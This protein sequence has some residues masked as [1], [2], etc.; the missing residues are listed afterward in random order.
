MRKLPFALALLAGGLLI[1]ACSSQADDG[2]WGAAAEVFFSEW[3]DAW[4][5]ADAY[6]IARFYDPD[7]RV[8]LAQD[9]RT[10]SL[11]AGNPATGVGGD[12]RAWLVDWINAQYEPR[13]RSVSGTYIGDHS[14]AVVFN[15]D[16]INAAG[17]VV[18]ELD[19][20]LISGYTDLR[21]RDA[22]L[23]GGRPDVRLDWLDSLVATHLETLGDPASLGMAEA[24]IATLTTGSREGAAVFVGPGLAG[25]VAE[26]ATSSGCEVEYMVLLELIDETVIAERWLPTVETV[27]RCFTDSASQP[28]WW[29]EIEVPLPVGDQATGVITERDG[30]EIRVYNGS[31]QMEDLLVWG[32]ERFEMAGLPRPE[33]QTATFAPL[34]VCG[35]V[36][37][38]VVDTGDFGSNLVYCTDAH[39]ACVPDAARCSEFKPGVRFGLL[40]ELAHAWLVVN[41]D[42]DGEA[43]FLALQG[44]E[45]WLDGSVAWHERGAEQA[46]E[47]IAWG[48]MD[49][50]IQLARIGDPS[51]PEATEGF[52]VLTGGISLRDCG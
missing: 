24:E 9:Y 37:G 32:L 13:D 17:G 26:G 33:L 2:E 28:G 12:G 46:A 27:R 11:N 25:Y 23:D 19:E 6:D 51:C 10:L 8:E 49:E 40:H 1:A 43:E 38:V 48:L 44:L 18:M 4:A 30:T 21:W 45:V 31:A 35:G 52:R 16:E 14:A 22:H 47:I 34:P 36:P 29:N 3:S 39:S 15:V 50:E 20:G 42:G 41:L 7:V 5:G